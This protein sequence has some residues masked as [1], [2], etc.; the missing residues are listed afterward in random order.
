[1]KK[2]A[3]GM[4][5]G[6]CLFLFFSCSLF[7]PDLELTRGSIIGTVQF[8]NDLS[9]DGIIVSV[10]M[11]DGVQTESVSRAINGEITRG[12]KKT[13]MTGVDGSYAFNDLEPGD[14]ILSALCGDA[15]EKT[16]TDKVT[17]NKAKMTTAPVL[18]LTAVGNIAGRIRLDD[19]ETG[20]QGFLVFI[21]GTSDMAMTDNLGNFVIRAVPAGTDYTLIIM[22]GDYLYEW[23]SVDVEPRTG[24]E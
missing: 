11:I 12:V 7:S 17:V 24:V 13:S 20:N 2:V 1:M 21:A 14:Y 8:Q 9:H 6:I 5:V 19:A 10:E 3:I 22:K 15:K 18:R 23:E 4:G 16:K